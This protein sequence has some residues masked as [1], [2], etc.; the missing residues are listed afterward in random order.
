MLLI[1]FVESIELPNDLI[2]FRRHIPSATYA[3]VGLNPF[4]QIFCPPVM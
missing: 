4:E 1:D 3:D 2:R